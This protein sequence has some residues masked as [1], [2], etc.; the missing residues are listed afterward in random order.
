MH[1]ESIYPL[2]W[3]LLIISA[4]VIV[5]VLIII[6][7]RKTREQEQKKIDDF[8]KDREN[9][10]PE[11][12][13]EK[14]FKSKGVSKEIVIGIRKIIEEIFNFDLSGLKKNDELFKELKFLFDSDS[15]ADVEMTI[16]IEEKFNI[17]IADADVQTIKTIDYLVMLVDKKVKNKNT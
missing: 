3:V 4:I 6:L 10:S 16:A 5:P 8:N 12:F 17:K 7:D 1:S 15:M 13:Y 14:Y 11:A 2:I 9:L